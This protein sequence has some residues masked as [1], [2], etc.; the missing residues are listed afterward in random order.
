MMSR[1]FS[2]PGKLLTVIAA[3]ITMV[4][5]TVPA[6]ATDVAQAHKVRAGSGYLALGD[7]VAFGYRESTSTPP[8]DY[9]QPDT[10]V[11]YPEDVS[12]DF[13]LAGTN[14]ACPGETSTSF[15]TGTA[16]SNGCEG[17][18]GSPG[19]RDLFPLHVAYAGPQLDFAV[20]FLQRHRGTRLVSLTIGANDGFLCQHT[21]ADHC[22]A[23]LP[24]VLQTVGRNV[25]TILGAIRHD[26]HYV[27][28]IVVVDYYALDYRDPTQ[29]A[30]SQLLN[31]ELIS[32]S[33]PFD[34]AIAD[35]FGAFQAAALQ[36]GGDTCA[37]GLLT[38]LS[39]GGCGIHPSV[40]GQQLLA[41]ALERVVRT[42]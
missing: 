2:T 5:A 11:G 41:S 32:A 28:Q 10:F 12:A 24:A 35:G 33:E 6:S 18:S 23:E 42:A 3:V 8:P 25:G 1:A 16:P 29:V 21:T 40:A 38:T 31:D 4:A 34:V 22:A 39:G 15:I 9:S 26:A 7:S 13:S 14:A 20:S 37:A 36:A 19:Y 27:G 17:T 30:L